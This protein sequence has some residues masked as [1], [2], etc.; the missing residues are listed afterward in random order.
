MGFIGLIVLAGI[1]VNNAIV[2]IDTANQLRRDGGLEYRDALTK[3][4]ALR[5]RPILMTTLTTVLGLLPLTGA[6]NGVPG[7]SSLLGTGE[8]AEIR[9]PLA[10]SV[11]A[12]LS[13]ATVLTLVVVPVMASA[14]DSILGVL[15]PTSDATDA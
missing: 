5:L 12:G 8:G 3:A 2:L 4:G 10:V 15:R 7:L 1:V 6:L 9:T 11:I 13:A 14:V